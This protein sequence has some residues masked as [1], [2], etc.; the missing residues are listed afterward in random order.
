MS[1][2][3]IKEVWQ[4]KNSVSTRYNNNVY[5]LARHL[6]QKEKEKATRTVDL[7]ARHT[8]SPASCVAESSVPYLPEAKDR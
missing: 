8:R 6:R 3:I 2:K 5:T 7:H 1:D 4:A